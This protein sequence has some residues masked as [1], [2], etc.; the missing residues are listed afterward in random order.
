MTKENRKT[1]RIE[2][3]KDFPHGRLAAGEFASLIERAEATQDFLGGATYGLSPER[4]ADINRIALDMGLPSRSAEWIIHLA[5][6][7]G[8]R[9]AER[10]P[11]EIE[12]KTMAATQRLRDDFSTRMSLLASLDDAV[13]DAGDKADSARDMAERASESARRAGEMFEAGTDAVFSKVPSIVK[14]AGSEQAKA[15]LEPFVVALERRSNGTAMRIK[16][17]AGVFAEAVAETSKKAGVDI[18][19]SCD[20]AADKFFSALRASLKRTV[21][22]AAR[23]K[24]EDRTTLLFLSVFSVVFVLL[25]GAAGVAGYQSGAMSERIETQ[26]QEGARHG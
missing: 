13:A 19:A 26:T 11:E 23:S 2:P 6:G 24:R 7:H 14:S 1:G 22:Q 21:G 12:K 15:V 3:P 25:V 4:C 8:A 5:A 16:T 20:A 10:I 9:V 17:E 18:G